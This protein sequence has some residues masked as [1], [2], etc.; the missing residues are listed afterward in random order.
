MQLDVSLSLREQDRILHILLVQDN[1]ADQDTVG[2]LKET[3]YRVEVV[4]NCRDALAALEDR[5]FDIVL[6]DVE[7]LETD[8]IAATAAIRDREKVTLTHLPI[9]A[10]TSHVMEEERERY[11]QA[12]M[13]ASVSK[14]ELFQ[15]IESLTKSTLDDSC[16]KVR[17]GQQMLQREGTFRAVADQPRLT[18]TVENNALTES[19]KMLADIQAAIRA[20]D[21]KTIRHT[22]DALKGS[23]T[24]V[25]A[26]EAFEAAN[27]L[28]KTLHE[29]DLARAQDACRR[30]QGA[31][32]SLNPTYAGKTEE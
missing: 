28:E 14:A 21:V 1:L 27:T 16:Q 5:N 15:T 2:L 25:L 4:G 17:L 32:T 19:Q 10:V 12:G 23:I 29:D 30:L 8:G 9:I 24:S 7:P 31:L 6:M 11:L 22:A 3:G 18:P 26:K 20:G 13:D